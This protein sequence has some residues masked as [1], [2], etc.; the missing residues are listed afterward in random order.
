MFLSIQDTQDTSFLRLC[1]GDVHS[2]KY[3]KLNEHGKTASFE[4]I[5]MLLVEDEDETNS[6][7]FNLEL[8]VNK[9][10]E[11]KLGDVDFSKDSDADKEWSPTPMDN[12]PQD[13][14][15]ETIPL[16]NK[17]HCCDQCDFKSHY[18]FSLTRHVMVHK[19]SKKERKWKILKVLFH[20]VRNSKI[21]QMISGAKF[22]ISLLQ[23]SLI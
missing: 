23:G 22:V 5:E 10:I 14:L 20:Q 4:D 15:V 9:K 19:G 16:A 21:Q 18:M 8:I 12:D 1:A 6:E 17:M 3:H 7:E 11:Q 2:L 13:V